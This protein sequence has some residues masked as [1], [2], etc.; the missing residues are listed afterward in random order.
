MPTDPHTR[1]AGCRS[2][3][4]TALFSTLPTLHVHSQEDPGVLIGHEGDG[5]SRDYF[6]Q[7]GGYPPVKSGHALPGHDVS[8]QVRHCKLR[9]AYH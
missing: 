5:D 1:A 7:V 2:R 8:E 4:R 6:Q 9:G 3:S